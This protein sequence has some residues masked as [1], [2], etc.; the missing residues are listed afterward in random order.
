MKGGPQ[1]CKTC[2]EAHK[3]SGKPLDCENCP[4]ACPHIRDGNRKTMELYALC[5]N[6]LNYSGNMERVFVTGFNWANVKVLSELGGIPITK[7]VLRRLRTIENL[8]IKV[9]TNGSK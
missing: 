6:C 7:P 8:V 3:Q 1:F 5:S 4:D 9:S 2:R